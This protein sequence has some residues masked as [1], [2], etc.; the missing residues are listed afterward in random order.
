[1]STRRAPT[2]ALTWARKNAASRP[3]PAHPSAQ[4]WGRGRP[5]TE[6]ID[7]IGGEITKGDTTRVAM[8]NY[9]AN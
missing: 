6:E 1:M 2:P 7:G 8:L 5:K 3:A 9:L 4:G